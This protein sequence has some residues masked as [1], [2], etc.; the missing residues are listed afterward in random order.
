V[1]RPDLHVSL[2]SPLPREVCVGRGTALFVAGTCYC[3]TAA[4][5]A[6]ELVVDGVAHPVIAYG[7]PRLDFFADLHPGLDPFATEGIELDPGSAADPQLRSYRS[8]FWGVAPVLESDATRPIELSLRARL[9][10]GRAAGA[11]VASIERVG[12]I[13]APLADPLPAAD[14]HRARGELVAICM[15]TYNPPPELFAAQ[16]ASIREQSHR[17]WICVISDDRSSETG[18][19]TIQR[20]VGTDPRFVVS[21]APRRLG[22]YNNF[23]R[24]LALAPR[25]APFVAMADQDDR[26]HPDK[27]ERLLGA[28]G[29]AELVYSD[30]RVIARDGAVLADTYWSTRHNNHSD[31]LSLLVANS[32]TG[33]ASLLRHELLDVALPFPPAQFAHFHDHWVGLTA[34]ARGPI[35]FVPA[36]LYDYVQHRDA[37]LGHAAANQRKPLRQRVADQRDPHERVRMW[38]LHYFVDV[39]RLLTLTTILRLRCGDD[40]SGRNRL[41]LRRFEAADRSLTAAVA[42]GLRGLADMR[43]TPETL[44]AEWMLFHA[45]AWRRLLSASVRDRPQQRLRLDAIPPPSLALKPTRVREPGAA[46][47]IADKLAPLDLAISDREPPRVNLLIPTVDLAHFFGGYIGKLNLARRLADAGRR[48]RLVTVDPVG[49]LPRD[50]RQRIESYSGLD[51]LFDAVEV[52]F[53]RGPTPVAVSPDDRFIATTWWTAHIAD[54]ACRLLGREGFVYLIQEYE[55]FTFAMGTYAA[56]AQQSYG[57]PHHAVF[58]TELLRDYFRRHRIGVFVA[59]VDAGDR[60]SMAFQNAITDVVAPTER[61]L[62]QRPT[63]KLLFYARPEE[64]AARNMFELGVL[65]LSEALERGILD[66]WELWGIGTVGERRAVALGDGASLPLLPRAA[67]DDYARLLGDHDVGLALMYT[68]HPSLVP[69]EMA[70]GGLVTVTNTFENKT[71]AAMTAIS[72]NLVAVA[73]TIDAVTDGLGAA[74][75]AAG[76]H[77]R[78][79]RGSAVNWSRDWRRSFD[80]QMLDEIGAALDAE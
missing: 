63:R 70:A 62:A 9:S 80:D 29:D 7:M 50:W 21:A 64:H 5:Q 68:P 35:E 14:L 74:V 2:D 49:P 79:V 72:E 23:E 34:R 58:S 20:E 6:L 8:G 11:A 43:G 47:A 18:L 13:A 42:L 77:T 65:A 10:D 17:N 1:P 33:A 52:Q 76:D 44:G 71:A 53:G 25:A 22:F 24:A 46:D 19:E 27:L 60:R 30:Q 55:P 59:G 32:V 39:A 56:L 36:P 3:P 4:V 45:F 51:G 12:P 54:A 16:I 48:V 73:P 75:A 66:G 61:E 15:A 69:I 67:Q 57:F 38:R 78:R 31:L 28:I 26:W 41:A 37:S 40:L